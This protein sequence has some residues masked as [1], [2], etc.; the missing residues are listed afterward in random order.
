M[1][2]IDISW[3]QYF[4][5]VYLY[6]HTTRLFVTLTINQPIQYTQ[7]KNVMKTFYKQRSL[8]C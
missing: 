2:T 1:E 3:H 8:M 4:H 5:N 7:V 6:K